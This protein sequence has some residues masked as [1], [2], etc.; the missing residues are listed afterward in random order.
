[1]SHTKE[2]FALL[3]RKWKMTPEEIEPLFKWL[4]E[5]KFIDHSSYIPYLEQREW[6][7]TEEHKFYWKRDHVWPRIYTAEHLNHTKP[8]A[9]PEFEKLCQKY[10]EDK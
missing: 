10:K 3:D 2:S 1:M 6:E 7:D 8:K 9:D 4:D 5:N